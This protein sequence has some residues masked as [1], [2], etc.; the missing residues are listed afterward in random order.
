MSLQTV[1]DVKTAGVDVELAIQDVRQR[2]EML[3][4][5]KQTVPSEEMRQLKKLSKTW[6]FVKNKAHYTNFKLISIKSKFTS[7]ALFEISD[8]ADHI[9]KLSTP[10]M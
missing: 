1:S 9:R 10:R 4:R 8:F 6:E 5:Y 7:L 2:Y 3:I